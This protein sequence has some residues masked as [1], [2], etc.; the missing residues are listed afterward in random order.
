MKP[1]KVE[2]LDHLKIPDKLDQSV[3]DAIN[4]AFRIRPDLLAD[5][6]R[7]RATRAEVK[8]TYT[9]YYSSVTFDSSKGWL[10]AFGEQQGSAGIYAHAPTYDATLGVKRTV[11]DG[12]R[13]ENS[14]Q[15]A[16]VEEK[17]AT[18]EVHDRQHDY[19]SSLE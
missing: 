7:V 13:R 18:D 2:P 6:A 9:S 12:F 15:L 3:Q 14:I 11:F 5:Q 16:K 4:T 19:K 10:R 17:I 1:L 8:H